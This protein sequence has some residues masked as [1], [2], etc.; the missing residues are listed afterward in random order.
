MTLLPLLLITP[1]IIVGIV[2]AS[3]LDE[4]LAIRVA[5]GRVE[6]VRGSISPAL[7]ADFHDVVRRFPDTQGE[8]V[9]KRRAHGPE[10]VVRKLPDALAQRLRNVFAL[11]A[12]RLVRDATVPAKARARSLSGLFVV[13]LALAVV[14]LVMMSVGAEA[15]MFG[16]GAF[17]RGD[18]D[19]LTEE[20][21]RALA[22]DMRAQTGGFPNLDAA[23]ESALP[24]ITRL[25]QMGV[26]SGRD[27]YA[28]RMMLA[29]GPRVVMSLTDRV[30]RF[31]L[32]RSGMFES[33]ARLAEL[34]E[35]FRALGLEGARL[36]C[37]DDDGCS[38][39]SNGV[40][41]PIVLPGELPRVDEDRCMPARIAMRLA[42]LLE[43]ASRARAPSQT[44]L[45]L[46]FPLGFEG[47]PEEDPDDGAH[48]T[49]VRVSESERAVLDAWARDFDHYPQARFGHELPLDD[50]LEQGC[51]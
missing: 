3:R 42:R 30:A 24:H 29:Q 10:L 51:R 48:V 32:A 23:Y 44:L 16:R 12:K 17:F 9:V 35:G 39:E 43:P 21:A 6:L 38:I 34:Q 20:E 19:P 40:R 49:F 25:R 11:H 28:E 41:T 18:G 8:I 22:S 26:L 13:S 33:A 45:L 36:R 2:L 14:G 27:D 15:T 50:A 7:L 5:A 1:A 31:P 47:G 37:S 4:L 46:T